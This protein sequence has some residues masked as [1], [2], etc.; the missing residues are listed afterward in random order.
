MPDKKN[1]AV[2]PETK[3]WK[4][5]TLSRKNHLSFET[6][7][8]NSNS[9]RKNE[10]QFYVSKHQTDKIST[11]NI[12]GCALEPSTKRSLSITRNAL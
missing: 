3:V 4:S 1:S 2:S 8:K 12:D 11:P 9:S 6:K 7:H 10:I 5:E